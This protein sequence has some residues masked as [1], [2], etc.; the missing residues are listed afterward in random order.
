MPPG[1]YLS[2]IW[3]LENPDAGIRWYASATREGKTWRIRFTIRIDA[4]DMQQ[5]D[6]CSND[7]G[8]S[9]EAALEFL[10]QCAERAKKT[11]GITVDHGIVRVGTDDPLKAARLLSQVPYLAIVAIVGDDEKQA[12]AP[13]PDPSM[14]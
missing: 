7:S 3:F 8:L 9:E 4:L 10:G 1:S 5:T 11:L 13:R 6:G 14:N 2:A 12:P